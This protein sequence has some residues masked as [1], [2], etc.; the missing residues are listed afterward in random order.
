MS[1]RQDK[2]HLFVLFGLLSGMLVVA[3]SATIAVSQEEK[4]P[5]ADFFLGYQ[6]LNSGGNL[7]V[8]GTNPVQAQ[9]APTA[10]RGAG[11][12]FAYNFTR[13]LA[14]EADAGANFAS[15]G[16][17][18]GTASLGPRLMWRSEDANLFIHTLLGWNRLNS[19]A[20]GPHNGIG[21]ILGGGID[22]PVN[23][24]F[25]FRLLEADYQWASQNFSNVVPPGQPNLRRPNFGGARLRSG[26][27][28]NVGGGGTEAPPS[29]SCSVQPGEVMLGEPIT[30]TATG[31][32]FNPKH[33]LSYSWSGSGGKVTSKDNTAAIDTNGVAG[34]RYTVTA[35]LTDPKVKKGGE[36]SCTASFTVKE[37][38]KN[39]PTLSCSASPTSVQAGTASTITCTCTSPDNVP[40]TVASWNASGGRI[41]GSGDT[42]TLN[43][44]GASAGPI[45]VSATCT[46]SRGL[47]ASSSSTVTVETPPPPP[48]NQLEVRLALAACLPASS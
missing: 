36:A 44:T 12:A 9:A 48:V 8:P 47:T 16:L 26:V 40:V 7:P 31:S 13:N 43:T 35:H 32:N 42:A 15:P 29:A 45:T 19:P 30:A 41:S 24:H 20:S 21:A 37:P 27:V 22:L 38:P 5:K 23:K 2:R 11:V 25:A 1:P 46:D 4:P 18:I 14:L 33:T 6:W 28:F 34:G 10:P 17:N 3:L 39:P